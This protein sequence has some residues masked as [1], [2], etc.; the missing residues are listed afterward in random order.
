MDADF[1]KQL[2]NMVGEAVGFLHKCMNNEDLEIEERVLAAEAVVHAAMKIEEVT[3][4][5]KSQL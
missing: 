3:N 2:H 4:G 5:T 1:R